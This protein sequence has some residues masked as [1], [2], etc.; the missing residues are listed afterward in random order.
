MG[1]LPTI[2]LLERT[3]R[4]PGPYLFKVIGRVDD[5]FAARAV[6]AVREALEWDEDPP[7]RVREA[8]GGRHVA[9]TLEPILQTAQQVLTVYQRLRGLGGLVM[10]L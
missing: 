4:F 2:E 5:G 1:D 7:F 3:H 6:A 8:T 9:V 10:F